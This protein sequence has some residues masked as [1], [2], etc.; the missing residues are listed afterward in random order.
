M[1]G[2]LTGPA[3]PAWAT[4]ATAVPVQRSAGGGC[5]CGC[6]GTCGGEEDAAVQRRVDGDV[7]AM[8]ITAD[9]ARALTDAE[10]GQQTARLR[11]HLGG[12][13]AAGPEA[14]GARANLRILEAEA[15]LRPG[16]GSLGDV[17]R[18]AGLPTDAGYTLRPINDMP[19][20][21]LA[22]IPEG[23]VVDVSPE[24]V[25]AAT[26][27]ATATAPP[28]RRIAQQTVEF[29]ASQGEIYG[30]AA[31][32]ALSGLNAAT[33]VTGLAAAGEYSIGVVGIPRTQMNPFGSNFNML[34]PAAP[35]DYWGH[36]ALMVRQN[37]RI[38]LVRGFNPETGSLRSLFTLLRTSGAVEAGELALPSV[39]SDDAHLLAS[40]AARS[41]EY[42]ITA[43]Q[44]AAYAAELHPT[45]PGASVGAPGS[46]TARPARYALAHPEL[47]RPFCVASNCGLWA[48]DQVEQRLG[49]TVG[50]AGQGS[51]TSLGEG[52]ASVPGTASQGRLMA[53]AAEAEAAAASGRT[54]P[55]LGM[56]GA[57]GGAGPVA[58]SVS[59]GIKVLRI[60]GRVF[61]VAGIVAGAYEIYAAS[62]DDRARTAAGVGGGFAGGFALGATAGLVCGPGALACSVVAGLALGLAGALGGRAIADGM[63]DAANP[64]GAAVTDPMQIQAAM[65]ALARADA[66]VCPSCH[67]GP[68]GGRDERH[69]PGLPGLLETATRT[70]P[71]L[72]GTLSPAEVQL[73]KS[74]LGD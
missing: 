9:W 73:I 70:T 57:L 48:V 44:A 37:G 23:Q 43:E 51:I 38:T 55:A 56:P 17:P 36:T 22:A 29:L 63:Y 45:G 49:G 6:D 59:T 50:R 8:S 66:N 1:T 2:L 31:G 15:R 27:P 67:D 18:P 4:A 25:A 30:P 41:L 28:T 13:D 40:N 53:F 11:R 72:S 32:S 71:P 58:G 14:A 16:P 7:T 21:L 46:Y 3:R 20:A 68:G 42:P 34:D 35:L 24:M 69:P 54:S 19:P 33:R 52:G 10:L 12:L 64:R 39:V 5:G 65:E 47:E 61:L 74:W 62:P 60:G 26:D